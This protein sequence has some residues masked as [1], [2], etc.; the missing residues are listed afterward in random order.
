MPQPRGAGEDL[1]TGRNSTAPAVVFGSGNTTS[2]EMSAQ[3]V[4]TISDN[5]ASRAYLTIRG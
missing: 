1:Q 2:A 4:F 5:R 3:P